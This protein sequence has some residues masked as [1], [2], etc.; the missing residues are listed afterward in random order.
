MLVT[1]CPPAAEDLRAAELALDD[2]GLAR[3]QNLK[4]GCLI[5]GACRM[6]AVVAG[7]RVTGGIHIVFAAD[8][9]A[10][11]TAPANSHLFQHTS[12]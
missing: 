10:N 3:L 1:A 11:R 7:E 9:V 5:A 8:F 6:G 12:L 4:T 2:A